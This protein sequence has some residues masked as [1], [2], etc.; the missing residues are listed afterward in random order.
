MAVTEIPVSI[1][2]GDGTC[3]ATFIYPAAGRHPGVILWPDAFGLRPAM[4]DLGHR[5]AADG[6]AVLIPNPF[7]R[8]VH[9]PV[10]DL[11]ASTFDFQNQEQRARLLSLMGT[12]QADG[13]AE[14]DAA[15][16]VRF[17]DAH[18]SVDTTRKIGTQ[19]YC[20]GGALA[21]RTAASQ[22]ARV[23]AVA[24]FHG[25]G[26]VTD[27]P[28]S[29]HRLIA[30]MRA[31]LYIGVAANDDARQPAAKDE[32]KAALAA[33]GVAGE[34][35]LYPS[36]HGWC[37]PDMRIEKGQPIYDEPQAARAWAKLLTLYRRALA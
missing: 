37:V 19:G 12:L 9:A 7:Y 32:L 34:V 23:G 2:T 14:K 15:A 35:E 18:P 17:L 30:H 3:D 25:G 11:D 20:M 22:P 13:A 8:V 29:P 6:Y 36:L 10:P 21:F 5:L 27:A 31:H 4:R 24:S 26:L 1:D 28:N 16:F 33:A